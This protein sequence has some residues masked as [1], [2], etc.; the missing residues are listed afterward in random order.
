[1]ITIFYN[2]KPSIRIKALALIAELKTAGYKLSLEKIRKETQ[3]ILAL[4]GDGTFVRTAYLAME[5]NLPILNVRLGR[6]GFLAE[7]NA[8]ETVPSVK[9]FFSGKYFID[10]RPLL[11]IS[12]LKNNRIIHQDV[13]LNDAVIC[14]QGIA[15][16]FEIEAGKR[17]YR[18]DGLIISSATGST[19]YNLAAGGK[20]L[21]PNQKKYLLTPI[22][23][24]ELNWKSQIIKLSKKTIVTPLAGTKARLMLTYDGARVRSLPYRAQ[25]IVTGSTQTARFVRFKKYDFKKLFAAKFLKKL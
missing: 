8:E 2:K 25:I 11:N 14:R 5:T 13:V 19:A 3:L 16:L 7:I 1:M 18:A 21:E 9:K 17:T 23:P 4:G 24:H 12:I 6:L 22:C 20:I 15:R 10:S